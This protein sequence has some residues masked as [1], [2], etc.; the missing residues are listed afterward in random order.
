MVFGDSL[1]SVNRAVN[2]LLRANEV[3]ELKTKLPKPLT[4]HYPSLIL[5]AFGLILFLKQ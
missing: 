4:I 3:T 5:S 1:L 2:L